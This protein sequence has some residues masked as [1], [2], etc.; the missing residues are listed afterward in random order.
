MEIFTVKSRKLTNSQWKKSQF[1][2]WLHP[3]HSHKN[4]AW[5]L[6]RDEGDKDVGTEDKDEEVV[7]VVSV[8]MLVVDDAEVTFWVGEVV[9][10]GVVSTA[11]RKLMNI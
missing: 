10:G 5:A 1:F 8:D 11:E 2:T 4:G 6:G 7:V 3:C 9:V